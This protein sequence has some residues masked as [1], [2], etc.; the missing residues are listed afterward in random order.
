MKLRLPPRHIT[1]LAAGTALG[2]GLA[3]LIY[4]TLG[5]ITVTLR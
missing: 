3:T 4:T 1:A 2:I 5:W